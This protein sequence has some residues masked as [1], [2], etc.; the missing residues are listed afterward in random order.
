MPLR[1]PPRFGQ[2]LAQARS[3]KAAEHLVDDRLRLGRIPRR[4]AGRRIGRTQELPAPSH[5]DKQ[6]QGLIM[7]STTRRDFL[8]TAAAT[9]AVLAAGSALNAH[10]AGSDEIRV[11]LVG[12]GGR[13]K[14]AGGDVLASTDGV[15]IVALADVFKDRIDDARNSLTEDSKKD[16][17]RDFKNSV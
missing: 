6:G 3:A 12:C 5:L 9:T 11:G 13:G 15:R 1:H 8:K 17:A 16:K 14:G 4:P 2:N 7:D 10:A